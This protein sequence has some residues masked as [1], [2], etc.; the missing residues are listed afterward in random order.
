MKK[1]YDRRQVLKGMSAACAAFLLPERQAGAEDVLRIAGQNVEIQIGSVSKHTFRLSILP[2]NDGHVG[3][4]PTDGSLVRESWAAPV[5]KMRGVSSARTVKCGDVNVRIASSPLS[6][7]VESPSGEQIQKIQVDADTGNVSFVTGDSPIL[8]LGEG[9]PQFDRRGS[10]ETMRSGQGGYKLATHGGRV[11]IPWLIG[12]SGWAMFIHQP[13]GTFDFTGPESKFKPKSP[14]TA[15]PLDIFFVASREPAT[16]MAEYARLTGHPEMPPLW[17]L[18]YQQSHRTLASREEILAEAKTFRDKKLPCDALI[19]LGTGFCPSGWNTENGSF[20]WN[21]RVFPDPKAILDEFHK[22]HFRAVLHVAILTRKL[23]GTVHDG[24][25][26]TRFDEQEASCYWD[27]HRTDFAMGVDGWWPD[28]GDPLDIASRLTRNRMY[29]EGPQI[30]RPN[31]RPYALHRNGYAGMQRYAS[32]LWS[33]DVYSTWETLKVHIPNAINTALSGIP[34]WGTDI[35]GFV[36]TKEFTAEL[37]L[38]WFQ[39]GAFCTLFRC[40]GRTWKLRLPWGWDTGDPGPIE[41]SNY[42][43]A[44]IPDASQLHNTQVEP[45]CRKYMELRYRMLPYLYSAV[46]ECA[47]TGTPIMRALW[48]HYPDDPVAVARDDEYLWGR[49]VLVAPVFEKGAASRRVY[50]PRGSWY[51]FWTGERTE[52]GHEISR[53]IDLETMPLYVRAGAILPLGPVKQYS[54]EKVDEPL[55]VTIYPGADGSF[56]LYEDDGKS[57]NYRKGDWMGI[58]MAWSDS[59]RVLSLHL[60]EGSRMLPPER[61]KIEVKLA[62][63][64]RQIVFEGRPLQ[65]TF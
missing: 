24:C 4:I 49:D 62:Q 10:M 31:E 39:F 61:R 5:A 38:R 6:F 9:G 43:G 21:S 51:D 22:D 2:V 12:T 65:V 20:A 13:F 17:S 25:A 46:R 58:K 1:G 26:L 52:G 14:D 30:D 55:S 33:G 19:Y 40:H 45:I 47:A 18:G 53:D 57:F 8:A 11:P 54:S 35:G 3:T 64:T 41:I 29:W 27:A 60:A 36:P 42:G 16:I 44:A 48:L 50:L 23:R 63:A 28:E 7:T 15:L 59:R 37:Y 34:F 32:F 56:L